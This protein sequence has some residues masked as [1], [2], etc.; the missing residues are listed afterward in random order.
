MISLKKIVNEL[1]DYWTDMSTDAQKSYLKNHPD[2]PKT[3][4]PD[5]PSG[6]KE[7]GDEQEKDNWEKIDSKEGKY[8]AI[9]DY[10]DEE[11]QDET[12]EYFENEKTSQIVPNAFKN[13]ADMIQKMK[14]AKPVYLSSEKMEFMDNTDAGDILK[15]DNALELG[16]KKAK[17]YGKDWDRLE[18]GIKS[19]ASVPP[20]M[21]F[22]DKNGEYYLL[23]GN[24]RLMSFTA[25]GKKLPIKVID[26]E[27]TFNYD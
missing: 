13:K 16:K 19:G 12:G 2:S 17:E 1:T 7:R 9:R 10:T 21:A 22:K 4:E 27:G 11:Y 24:T 15:S 8:K 26:Y 14:S 3:I 6:K 5:N 20:P 18:Q 25:S 23:A